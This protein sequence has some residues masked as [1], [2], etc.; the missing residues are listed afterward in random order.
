MIATSCPANCCETWPLE[1]CGSASIGATE[2]TIVAGATVDTS[3]GSRSTLTRVAIRCG[4]LV[5]EPGD[6]IAA[7]RRQDRALDGTLQGRHR[8]RLDR[9]LR[10]AELLD[11][12]CRRERE[13]HVAIDA[14]S[15]RRY[16]TKE[17]GAGRARQ[18]GELD[19]A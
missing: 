16:A 8:E 3:I 10:V 14:R 19:P 17:R 18:L 4:A 9:H 6:S 7:T 12:A 15:R 13:H 1:T 5:R 11:R 2:A